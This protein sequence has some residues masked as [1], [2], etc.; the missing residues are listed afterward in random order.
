MTEIVL[1]TRKQLVMYRSDKCVIEYPI[2][3]KSHISQ[4]ECRA[5]IG[6][7][8]IWNV[9]SIQKY[10]IEDIVFIQWIYQ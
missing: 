10:G 8:R 6:N 3:V 1:R 2:N 4:K 5:Q 9:K 7:R